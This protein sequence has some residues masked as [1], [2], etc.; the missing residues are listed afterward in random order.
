MR[1]I[2]GKPKEIFR[3]L[4][5]NYVKKLIKFCRKMSVHERKNFSVDT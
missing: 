1:K 4:E 5:R 2:C 3:K